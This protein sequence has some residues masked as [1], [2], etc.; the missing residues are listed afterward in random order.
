MSQ[1]PDPAAERSKGNRLA[2]LGATLGRLLG[3][4]RTGEPPAAPAASVAGESYAEIDRRFRPLD[5]EKVLRTRSLSLIPDAAH[6]HGGKIAFSEW[7]HVAGVFQSLIHLNLEKRSA[8]TILDVGCG[9]GLLAIAAEPL[10]GERGHV[11][12]IDVSERNIAFCRGHFPPDRFTFHHLATH[13]ATYAPRQQTAQAPWSFAD[14][15]FDMVTALSVWTHL[16]E[17]DA[18]FYLK[19]VGR[20]LKPGA[21]AVITFFVL[22]ELYEQTRG[23]RV[24]GSSKYHRGD[25]SIDRFD[26]PCSASGRWFSKSGL[27]NPEDAIAVT[28]AGI[29]QMAADASLEWEAYHTGNWKEAP[30]LYFQDVLVFRRPG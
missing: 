11:H 29:E 12:G 2:K 26:Q 15:A 10:L 3:G 17:P 6:R 28:R 13:N 22:D 9:T 27:K 1:L 7:C 19:E 16:N 18:R 24:G 30:G 20:V 4:R 8:P 21:R 14:A 5:L 25:Q 23:A